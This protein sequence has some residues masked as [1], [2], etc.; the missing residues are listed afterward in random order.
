MSDIFIM[1][2]NQ[3]NNALTSI[4]GIPFVTMLE[5]TGIILGTETVDLVYADAGFD[6]LPQGQYTV[7]VTHE[8]VTPQWVKQDVVI[9]D[10]D[11]VVL[12]TFIY[13]EPERILQGVKATTEKRL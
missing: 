12:L 10:I 7:I 5:Q 4:G 2:R 13:C 8:K 11:D 1:V 6:D 3:S 9:Q